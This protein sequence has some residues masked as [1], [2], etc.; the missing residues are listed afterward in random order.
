M[1]SDNFVNG[2]II[3]VGILI[4]FFLLLYVYYFYKTIKVGKERGF[5][6]W[7]LIFFS[8]IASPFLMYGFVKATKKD[9]DNIEIE[10]QNSKIK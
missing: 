6:V 5:G 2:L 4:G 10:K 7:F 1:I 9:S 8:L 3:Y